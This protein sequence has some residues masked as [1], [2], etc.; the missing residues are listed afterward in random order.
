MKINYGWI[1]I[2]GAIVL[3]LWGTYSYLYVK[4]VVCLDNYGKTYCESKNLTY[5]NHQKTF[6]G[7]MMICESKDFNPREDTFPRIYFFYYTEEEGD[8]CHCRLKEKNCK[9]F[10]FE[11]QEVSTP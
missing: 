1:I 6:N 8:S 4:D 9:L 11:Q 2:L 3:I 7:N 10:A 5:K